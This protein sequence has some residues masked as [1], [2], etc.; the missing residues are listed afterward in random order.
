MTETHDYD[1]NSAPI[2]P[3][4]VCYHAS[5]PCTSTRRKPS[6]G[7]SIYAQ[8]GGTIFRQREDVLFVRFSHAS[9]D[10]IVG[11][12]YLS[13]SGSGGCPSGAALTAWWHTL[14]EDIMDCLSTGAMLIIGTDINGRTNQGSD[15]LEPDPNNLLRI[16]PQHPPIPPPRTNLDTAPI[17]Q[18]G[19]MLLKT[20]MITGLH[21]AN[22]RCEGDI[23]GRRTSV[24]KRTG[25]GTATVDYFLICQQAAPLIAS[26]HVAHTPAHMLDHCHIILTLDIPPPP[27]PPPPP[28]PPPPIPPP[29]PPSSP[30]PHP[31]PPPPSP[32]PHPS[33]PP[34]SPPP[35]PAP[36]PSPPPPPP[37]PPAHPSFLPY[38][39]DVLVE[40][41][42]RMVLQQARLDQITIAAE[43]IIGQDAESIHTLEELA[44]ELDN[45]IIAQLEQSGAERWRPTP[46]AWERLL[47]P[48]SYDRLRR[49]R[50][51][52]RQKKQAIRFAATRGSH[53]LY[54]LAKL[55]YRTHR[56]NHARLVRILKTAAVESLFVEDPKAFWQMTRTKAPPP[57]DRIPDSDWVSHYQA[58]YSTPPPHPPPPIHSTMR[59]A[60]RPADPP[61][62]QTQWTVLELEQALTEIGSSKKVVG[63]IN[64]PVLAKAQ[65]A[66]A[67]ML[68]IFNAIPRC[69]QMPSIWNQT[70]IHSI[71]KPGQDRSSPTSYR[72]LAL[73]TLQYKITGRLLHNRIDT[74]AELNNRRA[75]T[76]FGFRGGKGCQEATFALETLR[77]EYK[78]KRQNLYCAFIDIKKAYDSIHRDLLWHKLAEMGLD[79]WVLQTIKSLYEYAPTAIRTATGLTHFFSPGKGVRQGCPLSPLLFGLFFD[80]ISHILEQ[81]YLD[82]A[83]LDDAPIPCLLYADDLTLISTSEAGLQQAL[84][85][86]QQYC[87]TWQLAVNTD[88]TKT[89]VFTTNRRPPIIT[90]TFDD[91]PIAQVDSFKFLGL[92]FHSKHTLQRS[93]TAERT[94]SG[95]RQLYAVQRKSREI[96]IHK[97][98]IQK[99]LFQAQILPILTYGSELWNINSTLDILSSATPL[100]TLVRSDTERVQITYCRDILGVRS[101]TNGAICLAECAQYPVLLS[102]LKRA[103]RFWNK[104]SNA[105]DIMAHVRQAAIRHG[106]SHWVSKLFA[107]WSTLGIQATFDP[108]SHIPVE[109]VETAVKEWFHNALNTDHRPSCRQYVTQIRPPL[110]TAQFKLPEYLKAVP[111]KGCRQALAQY[112]TGG[113]N[114]GSV[115]RGGQQ[116]MAN[117]DPALDT[118]CRACGWNNIETIETVEHR[119]F[120]CPMTAHLRVE[121]AALFG[122]NISGPTQLQLF[123]A[124]DPAHVALFCKQCAQCRPAPRMPP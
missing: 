7:T 123:L 19:K 84:H 113:H 40:F 109:Q 31:S 80:D 93:A 68:A 14:Q 33:P 27:S 71:A 37:P 87:E 62:N 50:T 99:H 78:L 15:Y 63:P 44:L 11:S 81:H 29:P 2:H 41:E 82:A 86:V 4:S 65:P 96:G 64:K 56:N 97:P 34:P 73:T 116:N 26:L 108:P 51:V 117:L 8:N 49:S 103:T 55:N 20:C 85:T 13:P 124:Q 12:V 77:M 39:P 53:R 74:W 5:R 118:L 95:T 6:G 25:S 100:N 76:Q 106:P 111:D 92:M 57:S 88:K 59:A 90:A 79:G 16:S 98:I 105:N 45:V 89:M 69:G 28:P 91:H 112:R 1:N 52:L 75:P 35:D 122:P 70:H 36:P 48:P 30:P 120:N 94:L 17:N 42:R 66:Y 119:L 54:I 10:I 83:Q 102:T 24:G 104:T 114:L 72:G 18:H 32:H 67:A 21:I 22:G 60:H 43:A 47:R 110:S 121:H 101:T 38:T 107:C 23:P 115:H 3:F 61:L 58:L 46:H 9:L